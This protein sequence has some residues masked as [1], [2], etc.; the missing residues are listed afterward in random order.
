M[1]NRTPNNTAINNTA[2]DSTAPENTGPENT[3]FL[4]RVDGRVGEGFGAEGEFGVHLNLVIS[5]IGS[6]SAAA[7]YGALANP[8]PGHVPFLICAPA[9]TVVRPATIFINKVTL[10]HPNLEK[11]AWG[12]IQLG[13]AQG[14]L[15]TVA[16]RVLPAQVSGDLVLLVAVSMNS[17][18]ADVE[19]TAQIETLMRRNARTAMADAVHDALNPATAAEVEAMAANRDN[20]SNNSYSGE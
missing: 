6:P 19:L 20:L 5:R 7:A 9:G 13:I 11:A 14:V 16:S 8:S 4:A 18:L 1:D 2:P 17:A 3:A 10:T 12:A 15:D